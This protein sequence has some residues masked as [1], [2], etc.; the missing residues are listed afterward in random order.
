MSL[1]RGDIVY[2][3]VKGPYTSKPRPVVIVQ[4]PATLALMESV[5][6]CPITSVEIDATFV[7]VPIAEGERSG[8]DRASWIM[9]DKIVTVPRSALRLPAVGKL[10]ARELSDLEEALRN[11]LDL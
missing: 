11:W 7:R 2:V 9:A 1:R 6:V 5:T 4:A 10:D 3:A 8:L